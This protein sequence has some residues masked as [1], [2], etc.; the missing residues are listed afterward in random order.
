MP[1]EEPEAEKAVQAGVFF[2]YIPIF[3]ILFALIAVL[4]DSGYM[5]RIAFVLD[6]ILSRFG[7]HGQS[8]LP[9]I[10]G[11]VVL[12]GCSIRFLLR[13]VSTRVSQY[14]PYTVVLVR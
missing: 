11:G 4:E 9:M 8:T 6:R 5:P 2:N 13:S 14:A 3:F 10:L 1:K 7:L 12:G